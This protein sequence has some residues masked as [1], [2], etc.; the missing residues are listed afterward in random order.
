MQLIDPQILT[1]SRIFLI[2][3]LLVIK[4]RILQIYLVFGIDSVGSIRLMYQIVLG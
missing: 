3:A 1:F 4:L 2:I